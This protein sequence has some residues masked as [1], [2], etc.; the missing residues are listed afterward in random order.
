L[1]DTYY[2][3]EQLEIDLEA[4]K[5]LKG[6]R[7]PCLKKPSLRHRSDYLPASDSHGIAILLSQSFAANFSN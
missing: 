4:A 5:L 6:F 2:G 7:L 1:F 3:S